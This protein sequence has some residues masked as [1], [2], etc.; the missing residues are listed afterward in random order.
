[1]LKRKK[2]VGWTARES[3]VTRVEVDYLDSLYLY[4][5]DLSRLWDGIVLEVRVRAQAQ[6]QAQAR[7]RDDDLPS[8]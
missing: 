8:L 1:M 4:L 5:L 7:I 3:R 6:A 2:W